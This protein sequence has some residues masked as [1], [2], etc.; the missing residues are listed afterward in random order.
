[1]SKMFKTKKYF[2][3]C[4]KT[5]KNSPRDIVINSGDLD[6]NYIMQHISID[7]AMIN[8]SLDKYTNI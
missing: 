6:R 4:K 3:F 2:A 8:S 1:M 5:A 7:E